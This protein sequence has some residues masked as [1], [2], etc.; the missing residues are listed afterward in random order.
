MNTKGL[1]SGNRVVIAQ[2]PYLQRIS[3]NTHIFKIAKNGAKYGEN[4]VY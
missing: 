1:L 4:R 3:A 2:K